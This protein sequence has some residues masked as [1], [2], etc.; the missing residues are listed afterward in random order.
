MASLVVHVPEPGQLVEVRQCRYVVVEV[1]QGSLPAEPLKA[2]RDGRAFWQAEN[3]H[4]VALSSGKSFQGSIVLGMGF[5][6]EP[7]EAQTFIEKDPR[8]YDVLY[9]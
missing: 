5:V 2:G 4:L 9:P 7:Q 1:V 3:Q 8:N 6:L